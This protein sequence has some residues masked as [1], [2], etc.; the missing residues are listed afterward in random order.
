MNIHIKQQSVFRLTLLLAALSA[1]G[2]FSIDTFLPAMKAISQDLN[3]SM[4]QTQL[5]ISVYMICLGVMNLFHGA[6]SDAIGRR[7]IVLVAMALFTLASIGCVFVNSLPA[8]LLMRGIQGLCSGAGMIVGR[9]IIRD[10][11]EGLAAQKIM[12]QVAML[13]S[14]AP[15]IA[16][17][18]GGQLYH[19][20]GWHSVFVFLF[21]FG[22]MLF[23]VS[24]RYLP[25]T[26]PPEKRVPFKI[27]SLIRNYCRVLFHLKFFVLSA[28]IAAGT[29]GNFIFISSSNKLL[30][31]HLNIPETQFFWLFGPLVLGI[32]L[33]SFLSVRLVGR[34][35]IRKAVGTGYGLM[36]VA[37]TI[38]C[39][40]HYFYPNNLWALV[41]PLGVYSAGMSITVPPMMV[42]I[43]DIFP[44][45]RGTASSLQG[46]MQTLTGGVVAGLVAPMVWDT[47]FG[48]T[49]A[50]LCCALISLFLNSSYFMLLKKSR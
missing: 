2:P 48:L 29:A 24:W 3:A 22:L 20:F 16:P 40:Y 23:G 33:G 44:S 49:L 6:V 30:L 41:L 4:A 10:C 47:V 45:L 37:A 36:L 9:A 38:T 19:L 1:I 26:H 17:I 21:F 27:P 13:F 7:R 12:A 5:T 32:M 25:E 43:M 28:A 11:F 34:L 42:T 31:D 35:G 15:A 14:L 46:A 50:M 8:L 39:T 18:L